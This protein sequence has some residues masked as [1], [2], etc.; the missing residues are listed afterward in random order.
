MI[1]DDESKFDI[2]A[3]R[4]VHLVVI[5][6]LVKDKKLKKREMTP[7]IVH[8]LFEEFEELVKYRMSS[9][10]CIISIITQT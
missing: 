6:A 1:S 9:H 7:K 2:K 4:E 3:G 5:R 8:S 10:H